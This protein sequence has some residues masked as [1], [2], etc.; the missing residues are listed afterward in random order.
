MGA[1]KFR[2][3]IVEMMS[4]KQARLTARMHRDSPFPVKLPVHFGRDPLQKFLRRRAI[5]SN[6]DFARVRVDSQLLYFWVPVENSF[7]SRTDT[8]EPVHILRWHGNGPRMA[9]GSGLIEPMSNQQRVETDDS[10]S[11]DH[12][13]VFHKIAPLWIDLGLLGEDR[14]ATICV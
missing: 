7:D 12:D 3:V 14:L 6:V 8:G 13:H 11:N 9:Q 10:S 4:M 1:M 2:D 5:E